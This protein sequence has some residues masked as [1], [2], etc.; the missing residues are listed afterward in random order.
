MELAG[1]KELEGEAQ[2][3]LIGR[4]GSIISHLL[5]NEG[6]IESKPSYHLVG[7]A[8]GT[9]VHQVGFDVTAEGDGLAGAL[10]VY[11]DR[12]PRRLLLN[13]L[14][15]IR[16]NDAT[17]FDFRLD[18]VVR[19]DLWQGVDNHFL[20]EEGSWD[21]DAALEEFLKIVDVSDLACLRDSETIVESFP[22]VVYNGILC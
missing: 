2:Q 9:F 4:N 12:L 22:A 8:F 6:R 11:G 1:V 10:E 20:Q 7:L 3:H 18:T 5:M 21:L 13:L 17:A 16:V 19:L 14:V 15:R